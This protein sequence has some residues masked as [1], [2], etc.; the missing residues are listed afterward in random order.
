M[1]EN[2]NKRKYEVPQII[3][4]GQVP[5]AQGINCSG[6]DLAKGTC[7]GGGQANANVNIIQPQVEKIEPNYEKIQPGTESGAGLRIEPKISP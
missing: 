1:D 7:G 2:F 3:Q 5:V 6:G 4:L